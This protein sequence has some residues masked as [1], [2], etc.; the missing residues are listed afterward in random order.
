MPEPTE[1]DHRR[2]RNALGCF[3]TG[4]TIVTTLDADGAPVGLTA[5][6]FTSVSLD[7][8]LLLVCLNRQSKSLPV[9]EAAETF[10][11]NVL[12][13]EQKELAQLFAMAAAD[14]F[15]DTIWESGSTGAP[16]ITGSLA[17]FECSTYAE[18]DG[19][20]HLIMVG[21]VVDVRFDDESDPLLYYRGA[22]RELHLD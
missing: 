9:F 8:E 14:R 6:S 11:V 18:Y 3:G 2:F 16:I 1:F 4:V 20:D 10:A 21:R 5:N 13:V 22:Y 7:P 17:S 15:R 12:H 19:G